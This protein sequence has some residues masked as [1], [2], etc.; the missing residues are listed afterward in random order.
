[1]PQDADAWVLCAS[2]GHRLNVSAQRAFARAETVFLSVQ[3]DAAQAVLRRTG[4]RNSFRTKALPDSLPLP[5]E[6]VRAYQQV[7][8][9]LSIA[10]RQELP[11]SQR[12]AG[13]KMMVEITRQFA[14]R[15]MVSPIEAEYWVKLAVEL[16]ARG[17]LDEI[18]ATPAESTGVAGGLVRLRQRLR[19]RKLTMALTKLT[20]QIQELQW[21]IGFLDPL[22]DPEDSS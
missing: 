3:E 5:M 16:T 19:R 11:D 6:I 4:R 17:E 2:C 13:Y 8:G 18:G 21:A 10:L 14:P 20:V 1:M 22:R 15:A 12:L 7:Y 9:G